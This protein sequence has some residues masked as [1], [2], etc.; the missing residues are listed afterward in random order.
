MEVFEMQA[1]VYRFSFLSLLV[2]V[3]LGMV[4]ASCAQA[5]EQE[6]STEPLQSEPITSEHTAEPMPETGS[7]PTST[8]EAD[9][10]NQL[11]ASVWGAVFD[12]GTETWY[13]Y[14]ND[15]AISEVRDGKLVLTAKKGNSFDSWTMSYPEMSDFYLEVLFTIGD[16]CEGKDRYGIFFR[17]PDNTQGYLYNVACDGSYQLRL[18]DGEQFTDLIN[19]TV[20]PH[21]AKGTDVSQR[22]GVWAEGDQMVLY[23]NG[24]QVGEVRDSTYS[25]GTFGVN[26]AGAQTAGFTVDVVEAKI[27]DLP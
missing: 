26:I 14:D 9:P 3:V 17:A 12:D 1:K 27:W 10:R 16:S 13:Q 4:V 22:L 7:T 11:G 5:P 24:F 25:Q 8:P 18:W 21:I 15:Q 2:V 6:M 23:V 20:D 19:W